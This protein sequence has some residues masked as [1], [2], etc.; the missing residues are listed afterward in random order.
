MRKYI[1]SN[2]PWF[3]FICKNDVFD[4]FNRAKIINDYKIEC[5]QFQINS[6]FYENYNLW[7]QSE[8]NITWVLEDRKILLSPDEHNRQYDTDTIWTVGYELSDDLENK[9]GFNWCVGTRLKPQ[10]V[11]WSNGDGFIIVDGSSRFNRFE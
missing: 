5:E 10:G 3:Q 7:D 6:S 8:Q 1:F 9:T 2:L 4:E 11:Y